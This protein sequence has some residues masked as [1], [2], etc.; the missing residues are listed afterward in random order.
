[1]EG[2]IS[3]RGTD[4]GYS[5]VPSNVSCIEDIEDPWY[6]SNDTHWILDSTGYLN[7]SCYN[8]GKYF[9]HYC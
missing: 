9:T 7:L 2:P 4:K 3:Y 1:M 8:D 6:Y 5:W